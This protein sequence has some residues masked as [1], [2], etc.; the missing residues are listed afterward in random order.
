VG[1]EWLTRRMQGFL[2]LNSVT[3]KHTPRFD[4][5]HDI[6]P[7][8]DSPPRKRCSLAPV[9]CFF[10]VSGSPPLC[11]QLPPSAAPP[12]RRRG[13]AFRVSVTRVSVTETLNRVRGAAHASPSP[14]P[15]TPST[16]RPTRANPVHTIPQQTRHQLISA[17]SQCPRSPYPNPSRTSPATGTDSKARPGKNVSGS[18]PLPLP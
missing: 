12:S 10:F 14:P 18:P 1:S 8:F 11:L 7:L 3:P 6:R 13:R 15:T 9:C 17:P 2:N 4:I 5:R 16:L